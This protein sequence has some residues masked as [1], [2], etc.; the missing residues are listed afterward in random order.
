LNRFIAAHNPNHITW[1][2]KKDLKPMLPA[3]VIKEEFHK[4]YSAAPRW[5]AWA[6]GRVNLIGDHVDYAGG[7]VL[8]AAIEMGILVTAGPSKDGCFHVHSVGIKSSMSVFPED[9]TPEK[10]AD[11]WSRYVYATI[12]QLEKL[13]VAVPP[14]EILISSNL[15]IG[16]GLSSSAALEVGVAIVACAAAGAKL[17]PRD[18]ALAA[19]AAENG[20]F[21]GNQC[22]IMDQYASALGQENHAVLID[23]YSLEHKTIPLDQK[24]ADIVIINSRKQRGLVDSEYN[25]RRQQCDLALA[26]INRLSGENF[27]TLRHVPAE[28]LT[29][30]IDNM[31]PI[32]AKRARHHVS[33]NRRVHE[34][35]DALTKNDMTTAGN[36]LY[37]SH[38]SLRDDYEVSCGELDLIV[39]LAS[40]QD[41]IFGCRMTGG[42]FGGCAVA[43]I[44]PGNLDAIRETIG[45]PYRDKCGRLPQFY[46]THASRGAGLLPGT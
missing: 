46:K 6:P 20:P 1:K 12:K 29:G 7:F 15:P 36:L 3:N 8:P 40:Q 35:S 44:K 37:G 9:I 21:V 18:I 24:A 33:E 2:P 34:F 23:C 14:L 41:E 30:V 16:T 31:E 17:P 42:G 32:L 22:G 19:Q 38:E 4:Q 45:G 25:L 43:L 27:P 10:T 39:E 13:N 5:T 28:I 11:H 26:E